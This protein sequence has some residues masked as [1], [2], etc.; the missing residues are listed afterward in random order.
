MSVFGLSLFQD[1][2]IGLLRT[3]SE[4]EGF[5]NT[6]SSNPFTSPHLAFLLVIPRLQVRLL[7]RSVRVESSRRGAL[8][9]DSRTVAALHLGRRVSHPTT[10]L[11]QTSSKAVVP[12]TAPP[13]T[14]SAS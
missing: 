5:V 1:F 3:F 4:P 11:A 9:K 6:F 8:H 13:L 12:L 14:L 2:L 10:S 7:S